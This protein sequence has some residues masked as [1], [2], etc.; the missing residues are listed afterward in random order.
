MHAHT[1]ARIYLN[2]LCFDYIPL[3]DKNNPNNAF[4]ELMP[5]GW[6]YDSDYDAVLFM[7]RTG[8]GPDQFGFCAFYVT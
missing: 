5:S 7:D 4:R 3:P 2:R 1:N 6:K 8:P